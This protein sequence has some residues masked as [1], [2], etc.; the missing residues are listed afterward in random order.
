MATG[1]RW[2]HGALLFLASLLLA[3]GGPPP[4]LA[5][6]H[7]VASGEAT[8]SG[9]VLWTAANQETA[10]KLEVFGSPGLAGPKVFQRTL[11]S[12][13]TGDFTIK[14]EAR[15]LA[16]DTPY[17]YRFRR[18]NETSEVGTFRTA[19]LP[20]QTRSVR[21]AWSGDSD[22]TL[23]AGVP[24]FNQ[25]EALDAARAEQLDFFVYLGDLIY[26]DSFVRG[27][28]GLGPAMTLAE[29]RETWRVNRG[30]AALRALLRSTSIVSIWDDHE[31]VNDYDGRSVDPL[32]YANGRQA[33]FEYVP[34][35]ESGLL[36]DPSCAGDPL[37]KVFHWGELVDVIVLDERSCRDADVEAA[38]QGDLAPTLPTFLRVPAQLPPEPPAG[39]LAALADPSRTFLGPVQ[40]QRFK[41]ALENS[42]ARF[43]FVINELPI[44]QF[45]AA[46]YDRWE[47]YA[48]ERAEILDF[49]RE[50]GIPNVIFLTTD[51]HANLANDVF[52]DVF[53]DSESIAREFVTGPIARST[54][55]QNVLAVA[56]PEGLFVL[57]GI[58]GGLL[59]AECQAL[60]AFSYG[61][62]EVDAT[63]GT[64]T[65]SL[66]DDAGA[67]L[68]DDLSGA[69][70][71]E[72]LGP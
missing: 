44:Q 52:V 6:P 58:L 66:K 47:G 5:F 16:P 71:A 59:Q 1:P 8:S 37:F 49:I 22:G 23:V 63:A 60:D 29:Y 61:L 13:A 64:A 32:R 70:C 53:T 68:R 41:E 14:V 42:T 40:K 21:F 7:G 17:W 27:L 9:V 48:A 45:F 24:F 36:S 2:T 39:C 54:F 26:S 46:P 38:C 28:A 51:I 56:G 33:Y 15:G 72:T 62:V 31:V 3:P 20:A 55:A 4:P 67:V 57:R 11:R 65:V 30:F 10:V 12:A 43:K 18:G 25:F 19:P 69:P 50:K 34:S 35:S